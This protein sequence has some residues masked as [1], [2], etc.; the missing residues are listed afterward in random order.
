MAVISGGKVIEGALRR[1]GSVSAESTVATPADGSTRWARV[2]YDFAVE[3]GA[4]GTIG[5]AGA[6]IIPLGAVIMG[7][8]VDV[9]TPP[10]S[11]GGATIA[12]QVEGANDIVN[13]AAISGAPWSTTGRKSVIPAY[14]GATS[15]KTTAARDISAV[16]ATATLT[17]G[18][19]DVY[20]AYIET[21]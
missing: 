14:T 10:T 7:G 1:T 19:F 6:T 11:G 8:F 17:A 18:V 2:R 20:L 4:I 16:I 9:I 21:V 15:V 12:I 3:G 5:L 13:A